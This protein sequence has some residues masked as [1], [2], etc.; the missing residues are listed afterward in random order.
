MIQAFR[1]QNCGG[2]IAKEKHKGK[3]ENTCINIGVG[4]VIYKFSWIYFHLSVEYLNLA[5]VY[6]VGSLM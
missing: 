5:C 3:I 6:L 4:T 1:D 2:W